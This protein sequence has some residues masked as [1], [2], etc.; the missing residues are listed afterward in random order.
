MNTRITL[1]TSVGALVI[2]GAALSLSPA[3]H[4]VA[5]L[6][7][8]IGLSMF[9]GLGACNA[10]AGV[11]LSTPQ[12]VFALAVATPAGG[13]CTQSAS[14]SMHA[15]AA[16]RSL[17]MQ[18]TAS[19][20]QTVA[21]GQVSFV[22]TWIITPPPGT[23]VGFITMPVSFALDGT[24]APGS[25]FSFGRFLDYV[26]T[27]SDPNTGVGNPLQNFQVTGRITATGT[28]A[29]VFNGDV[30]FRNFNQTSLPMRAL[31]EM[32]LLVPQLNAG[33]VDFSNT[34]QASLTLP[35]GFTATTSSGLPLVFAPVPEPAT[36]WL[37]ALGAALLG[38][39]TRGD[40]GSFRKARQ[41]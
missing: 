16:T 1:N 5:L 36:S 13:P 19:G 29:L 38:W 21:A 11:S 26:F 18:L 20:P 2:A 14:G 6:G 41:T 15:A 25:S 39:V 9:P 33:S 35:P 27:I 8:N 31:V 4:A 22:D 3:A 24:V 40:S 17:G 32:T 7:G 30:S 34:A 10:G 12:D 28:T 23:P 37:W